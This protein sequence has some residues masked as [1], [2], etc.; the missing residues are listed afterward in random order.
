MRFQN[1]VN[2]F[3]APPTANHHP[4]HSFTSQ[5]FPC[6]NAHV[7]SAAQLAKEIHRRLMEEYGAP[8]WRKPLPPMDEL[9]STI[10]SQ[11]TTDINRDRAFDSL[12]ERFPT[13]EAVR[14]ANAHELIEAIRSA[15][16]ANQKGPRIQSA[17]RSITEERGTLKLDFLRDLPPEE[18]RRWLMRFKG[19]GPKTAAIVMQFSLGM[20]AF[21]VDTHIYRLSGRLALRDAK[22]NADAA[23]KILAD[24]FA[25]DTYYAAHLN[26]IRHG[27]EVCRARKPACADCVLQ[28]LCHYYETVVKISVA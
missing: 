4:V 11:N 19:V 1:W 6:Y 17:L 10:L 13:W 8:E 25:P 23:H 3:P 27:R 28:D 24:L 22:T 16:L 26:L 5:L 12:K 18:V 7:S 2:D 20:P 14:D 21:P 15:G 9:V